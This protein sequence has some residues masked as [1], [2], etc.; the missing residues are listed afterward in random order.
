MENEDSAKRH[1]RRRS[2]SL[3]HNGVRDGHSSS[4]K[5]SSPNLPSDI[6]EAGDVPEHH[7]KDTDSYTQ[8][9]SDWEMDD[10]RSDEGLQDDEET[11]LTQQER[12]KRKRR[13][14]RNTMMEER[15]AQ[16]DS[17]AKE[18]RR[19]ANAS[20]LRDSLINAILIGMWYTFSISISVYNKWMFS[21]GNLDF[22]FP[23][24]TTCVHM[25]VQ[26]TLASTVLL[27]IPS[28]RPKHSPAEYSP[29]PQHGDGSSPDTPRRP[30][31]TVWFYMTRI[32][33]CGAAT[34]LDIGL[35]NMSL[36]FISLTFYTM[37][38]SSVLA[39][40]LLF[41]FIFRLEKP[42]WRLGGIILLM[43]GGVVMMVFGEAAFSALGFILIMSSAFFSGF[44]W[45]LTQILLLRNPA[46]SNPFSTLF[47][48][49]PVMFL[50][51]LVI[52]LPVEGIPDLI[53]GFYALTEAR[54]FWGGIA[55]IFFP[56]LLA[57]LM[58]ASEFALLKR[59]SV[60]T[61][62]VCGIFKEVLTIS[63]AS[64][65][66]KDKLTP[67]NISGL[68]V[69]IS[70]IAAYNYI[71]FTRM[72]ETAQREAHAQV[73][74]AE[75]MLHTEEPEGRASIAEARRGHGRSASSTMGMI[76]NSLHI[77][78]SAMGEAPKNGER[79]SPVK[80][81]EDLE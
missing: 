42:S 43:I 14:R 64:I 36:K 20:M 57:F 24:F 56:G 18:E 16:D 15:I 50:A 5:T 58:T 10:M 22:H 37:C 33:P 44:R 61:L 28:L 48:L 81:P 72:R 71:K 19:L 1:A 27:L 76:R 53:E 68:L 60:V 2:S 25:M 9:S 8:S 38:K 31:M 67:V 34:G 45:S 41:A 74:Q 21:E 54:G 66:F 32:S 3:V 26:F 55:I 47:F 13:K 78:V 77:P 11:G 29:V 23:L 35:G 17:M 52:A 79:I 40:V 7:I 6:P 69:T 30:L 62:S 59:T 51:L 12:S 39:Y 65:V 80:R 46:T 70:S 75:P 73:L 63:V 49:T 4:R